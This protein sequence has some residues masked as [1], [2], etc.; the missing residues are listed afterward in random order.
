MIG[1]G[2]TNSKGICTISDVPVD[3]DVWFFAKT[4]DLSSE[5]GVIL[6]GDDGVANINLASDKSIIQSGS[7]ADVTATL[8]DFIGTGVSGAVVYFFVD[9]EE[10]LTLSCSNPVI[11]SGSRADI[12]ANL[13]CDWSGETV[14]F[15]IDEEE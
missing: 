3:D 6:V 4:D 7:R 9:V 8:K 11:Q 10:D 13:G 2:N 15:Y 1:R 12:T 5:K 14:E